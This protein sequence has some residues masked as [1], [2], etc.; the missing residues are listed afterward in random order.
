M[1]PV[2]PA[3]YSVHSTAR[4]L[5]TLLVPR[6]WVSMVFLVRKVP[7]M[8]PRSPTVASELA[9]LLYRQMPAVLAAHLINSALVV[10]ALWYSAE[11][12]LLLAWAAAIAVLALV[13]VLVWLRFRR[14]APSNGEFDAAR[15]TGYF[16]AGS[17]AAGV[18]WGSAVLLFVSPEKPESLILF[19]FVIGGM[20]AGAVTTL[21]SHPPAFYAYILTSVLPLAAALLALGDRTGL[22]MGGMVGAYVVALLVIGRNFNAVLVKAIEI[23][24][25]NKHLLTEMEGEVQARTAALTAANRR[26]EIEIEERRSA[27]AQ[28]ED[29]RAEAERANQAKSRFLAAAS[30][31]LRQPLQSMFMFA[32]VLRHHVADTRGGETLNHIERSLDVLKEM[33][34]SLLDV[35]RLDVNVIHPALAAVA[36]QPLLDDIADDYRRIAEGKGV[37]LSCGRR[38]E[39]RAT[40]DPNLLARMVRNLVENAI[41]YTHRGRVSLSARVA[42]DS[43]HVDVEDTGIGIAP[44]Q[45]GR[46]FEE[47]H[48]VGNPE[49]DKAR[50]LGLGLAIV[51][52]LSTILDHPVTVTSTLGQG[53]TFSITLPLAPATGAV[54]AALPAATEAEDG[55]GRQVMLIDDDE[56]VLQALG[57]VFQGW[58]YLVV[59][60]GSEDEA[61]SRLLPGAS[62]PQLIVAD[63]RLRGGRVGTDAIRHIRERC[64][65]PVPGIVLTGETDEEFLA[66]A[67]ALGAIVLHKPVTSLQLAAVLKRLFADAA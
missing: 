40:S 14:R 3:Q 38:C 13:R 25:Q 60:A 7:S 57:G 21:S 4:L 54:A 62:P 1:L 52:R 67:E 33:L 24:A 5:F 65:A 49:R 15:W 58:G 61:L 59:M 56:A 16:T 8:A 18:V 41:R 27:Q 37:V 12:A 29:A 26:L 48:Q 47:F 39:A 30:H 35:S 10:F 46:I 66:E 22:A 31:D 53:S 17:L 36:V 42:G 20:A 11:R 28:V 43:I 44:D 19:S 2:M 9:Q 51:Q 23:N 50:G 63:Y 45:L 32:D 64:A 34:D 6:L 55:D